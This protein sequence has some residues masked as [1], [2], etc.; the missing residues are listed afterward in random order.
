M[1]ETI[2]VRMTEWWL[3]G[4][5]SA[6]PQ[7]RGLNQVYTGALPQVAQ[8]LAPRRPKS[9]PA[10]R[11]YK[12]T[13]VSVQKHALQYKEPPR[14]LVG[15]FGERVSAARFVRTLLEWGVVEEVR[16]ATSAA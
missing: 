7:E 2:A 9:V 13:L 4:D 1:K 6:E 14:E 8:A 3:G 11:H 15:D 10:L 16:D 12:Q 5:Y